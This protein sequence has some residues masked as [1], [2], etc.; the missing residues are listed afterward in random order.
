MGDEL[1]IT[2]LS[3][4]DKATL[5]DNGDG[6]GSITWD[7]TTDD[8]GMYNV[9]IGADDGFTVS[10]Q[11]FNLNVVSLVNDPPVKSTSKQTL[12]IPAP[13]FG[14]SFWTPVDADGP[15]KVFSLSVG[16]V[17]QIMMSLPSMGIR[18]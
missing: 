15:E 8:A 2:A 5:V 17:T 13:A 7:T 4:L 12:G 10:E 11:S 14:L 9:T 18:W 3:G 6:T 16:M 1:T